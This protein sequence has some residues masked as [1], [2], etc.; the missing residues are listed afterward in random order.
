MLAAAAL[1]LSGCGRGG[2]N[3]D[4][5]PYAMLNPQADF[6]LTNQDGR[7]FRLSEH[8]G[9]VVL[10][11]FGYLS[12]PDICPTTLSKLSRVYTLLGPARRAKVLT[13]FVSIDTERDAPAKLKEYLSYFNVNSVGLTGG[14]DAVDKV[15]AAYKA[16]YKRVE[17]R[18]ALGYLYDH[19]DLVYL[20][21]GRGKVAALIH[22]DDTADAIAEKIEKTL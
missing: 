16:S 3:S 15:V 11:F 5:S 4:R 1:A 6:E 8:R 7:P 9:Q 14:R 13:V 21:D 18:S 22:A 20:I 2:G 17:T 10:L 12:C 19:S